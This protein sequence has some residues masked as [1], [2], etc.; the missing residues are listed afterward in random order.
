[1]R[2]AL[3]GHGRWGKNILKTL[4]TF[5]DV[6]VIVLKR[7]DEVTEDIKG[8]IIATPISTH[9]GLAYPFV[10]RGIPVFIE[11]P[12]TNSL[13]EAS[14]IE[15]MAR[16]SNSL[17]QVGHIHLHSSAF[18][19][20]PDVGEI[21]HLFFQG[22]NPG[23]VR[24][25]VS[26]LWDWLAHPLSMALTLLKQRPISVQAW[27]LNGIG[28]VLYKFHT[29]SL[30][31]HVSW[32]NPEKITKLTII[33][34]K[35]THIYDDSTPQSPRPL[36]VEMRA[37]VDAIKENSHDNSGLALGITIVELIVAAHLSVRKGGRII[38]L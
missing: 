30:I 38:S 32:L 22:L 6:E 1:M 11:K 8:A 19:A 3:L 26:V 23:P 14:L 27:D 20:I 36:E 16:S 13:I 4:Q 10:Q 25:D 21:Q 5:P 29:T 15:A 28:V 24:E 9:V 2:L 35:G 18:K 7:G 33:G 12:L 34:S 17:V 31:C 37:F